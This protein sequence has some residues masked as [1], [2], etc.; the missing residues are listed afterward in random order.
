VGT[1]GHRDLR[2]AFLWAT[3]A[4]A[5]AELGHRLLAPLDGVDDAGHGL[6]RVQLQQAIRDAGVAAGVWRQDRDVERDLARSRLARTTGYVEVDQRAQRL[7]H[8]RCHRRGQPLH[9]VQRLIN[10]RK[11]GLDDRLDDIHWI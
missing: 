7:A 10:H 5:R 1:D 8:L 3:D 4:D 2:R 6:D 11:D 9:G